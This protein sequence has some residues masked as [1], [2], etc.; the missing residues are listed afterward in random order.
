MTLKTHNL[1]KRLNFILFALTYLPLLLNAQQAVEI[2]NNGA[3][4]DE[5]GLIDCFDTDCTCTGQ[6]DNFYYTTCNPDCYYLPPCGPISLATKWE[7]NAE[8][9][10][11]SPL[12]AGDLDGDGIPEVVT[13]RVEEADLYILDGATGQIKYHVVNPNTVWPGGTAPAIADLDNDGLGEIVIVGFDRRLYCYRHDGTLKFVGPTLVGYDFRY[14]Y[15]VP[16]VADFN[17]DGLPE[18]NIG[19]Q[20][21]NGQTGTLLA[22]GGNF[23][24]DGEHP[25]RVAIGYSFASTVAVDVLPTGA[26]FGCQGLEIVAGNQVLSVSLFTGI[27]LPVVSAPAGYSDG[28]TSV[29]DFDGDGDLDAI[30]Q[31]RR[32]GQNI[33]YV[34]DIQTPTILR[35]FTL[36]NNWSEGASRINVAD[37]NGDGKLDISFVSH[38]WLYA[39]DNDFTPL[40]INPIFDPSSIT[41]SSIFDFCGDGSA[42]VVYRSE[43]KLQIL[44]GATGNVIW[45]DVCLSFTHIENPLILDVDADGKTEILIECGTNGSKFSGTVFAY[46]AVGTPNISTRK[47]WNQHGYFNTHINDDL[48]VPRFQQKQHLVGDKLQLN[49]FLNQYFNPT[50]PS[51]DATLTLLE[52]ICERDSIVVT[53]QICN[54]GDNVFPLH[55]PIAAYVGNPQLLAATSLGTVMLSPELGLG[56]CD[57][58]SFRI[59]RVANDSVYFVLNDNGSLAP[60]FNLAADFPVTGIGECRFDNNLAVMYLDYQPALLNLGPDTAICALSTLVL[61]ASGLHL[62]QWLWDDGS[63]LPSRTVTGPGVYTVSTTDF[64]FNTQTDTI[65]IALDENTVIEL[66]ADQSICPGETATISVTGFDYYVWT[67][68]STLSC[69]DCPVVTLTPNADSYVAVL[70][71]YNY[72]CFARDTVQVWLYE[73]FNITIDTTICYGNGIVWNGQTLL[74][75]QN[76]Q[77]DLQTV[78]GCD[79]IVVVRVTGTTL[80]VYNITVDTAVCLGRTLAYN[81]ANLAPETQMTFNLQSV[82]G[83]DS[84]VTVRVAPLD[85]FYVIET[86]V[87]CFGESSNIFGVAQDT[88]GEYKAVFAAENG[89]DSTHL[90][91][92]YVLPQIPLQI[93]ATVACFG[94]ADATLTAHVDGGFP[95]YFYV[96]NFTGNHTPVVNNIK[97]GTYTLTVTD[98]NN[99]TETQ[100]I[101][102]E[103]YPPSIFTTAVD[104]ARCYD[105][106]SGAIR[107]STDDASLMFKLNAEGTFG[108]QYEYL[109]LHAGTYIIVSQDVYGCQDT[110]ALTVLQ[111]PLI[112]VWLP[113]DT[114]VL[115]GASVPLP[116]G[117]EG[118]TPTPTE[119]IWSDTSFLSCIDC[120]NPIAQ[121][122]S[123]TV[124]YALTVKDA[125]GCAT[126]DEIVLT[127]D[128]RITVFLPNAMGGSSGNTVWL[129][130][131]GP[132]VRKVSSLRIYDRWGELMHEVRNAIPG[133]GS[134]GWDGR[135]KGRLVNPGVY[136]WTIE[137]ELYDGTVL[138]KTGDLTLIR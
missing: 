76:Y 132:A 131:F 130:G 120:P 136:V 7:S 114:T 93:N 32:G 16:N 61:N 137:L 17:E 62:T 115:L 1:T 22:S 126:S 105:E 110:S 135:Y 30:V 124:R 68:P 35:E 46:E 42:D 41:C 119:W 38:P 47:V 83:C 70:A 75:D 15:A 92:L 98:G 13:T 67:S 27:V 20:V 125:K 102:V 36:L 109:N 49:T 3:D 60:P 21:F 100:S 97:A 82:A 90:V 134:L 89:C 55:T 12:V 8:T 56:A 85:T 73:T 79:S 39:L 57:T 103:Q 37:L 81:G 63:T 111:P 108:Q 9:G 72:G 80:G 44:E 59:Q 69:S 86:R 4:D 65:T 129:P 113:A 66:G 58:V 18:I 5:D 6:C 10:T 54:E 133:D 84:T 107:V 40:W 117:L 51:P 26:C 52:S 78:N 33:V 19:N 64:C 106:Y 53:L 29:A 71:G 50:F 94:E 88:S 112:A 87:V 118:F 25:A 101:A 116:V 24:S 127:I 45:E 91:S 122:V 77:F 99:C 123:R 138:K 31:G 14:R 2:C 95:P 11:Y 28:F 128:P 34:W 43:D 23:F 74:P 96:W 104:S 121:H 48:S